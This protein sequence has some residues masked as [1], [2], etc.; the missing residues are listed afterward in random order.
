MKIHQELI[1]LQDATQAV[2][3]VE[4]D[5]IRGMIANPLGGIFDLFGS[6]TTELPI[7][8]DL[9]QDAYIEHWREGAHSHSLVFIHGFASEG[10]AHE[11][12]EPLN[13]FAQQ[14]D[15]STYAVRWPSFSQA[16]L[17]M[18]VGTAVAA[19][20]LGGIGLG[21]A[22][23][24]IQAAF[25]RAMS[26]ADDLASKLNELLVHVDGPVILVGHSLGARCALRYYCSS[27]LDP[28]QVTGVIGLAPA[29]GQSELKNTRP[30]SPLVAYSSH[31]HV[32][33]YAYPIGNRELFAS[34]GQDEEDALG[35]IGPSGAEKML[36]IDLSDLEIGHLDY[37]ERLEE[38]L[39]RFNIQQYLSHSGLGSK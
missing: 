5:G 17:A 3:D 25:Q 29:I 34:S 16:E 12:R 32:L 28:A 19:A 27:S 35:L 20:G 2:R 9:S 18:I 14:Y 26:N 4:R 21:L 1:S 6:P 36:G 13:R 15:C 24:S 10:S 39:S 23:K 31:D 38:V 30:R 8:L 37:C 7:P 22:A 11:W 33:R